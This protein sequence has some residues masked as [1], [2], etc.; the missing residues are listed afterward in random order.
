MV[1]S[2]KKSRNAYF[3][4]DYNWTAVILYSYRNAMEKLIRTI[5]ATDLDLDEM[6]IDKAIE[7]LQSL[8]E[9]YSKDWTDLQI[10]EDYGYEGGYILR[11]RGK[12]YETDLEYENR[13]KY[14]KARADQ[15]IARDFSEYERLKA[16]FEKQ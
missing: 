8:Q 15:Q 13:L 10:Y 14:D 11:L 9:K 12:R 2:Q 5:D 4:V 6:S 7:Y 3:I 1:L 16:L